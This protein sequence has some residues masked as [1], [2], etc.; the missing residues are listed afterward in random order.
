MAAVAISMAQ[1]HGLAK[2]NSGTKK[3]PQPMIA[4]ARVAVNQMLATMISQIETQD[5]IQKRMGIK[6][7]TAASKMICDQKFIVCVG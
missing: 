1:S 2:K 6:I 7:L 3:R 5:T 4:I